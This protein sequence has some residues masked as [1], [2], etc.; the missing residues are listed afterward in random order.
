LSSL[1]ISSY[2]DYLDAQESQIS[3]F[4]VS[5]NWLQVRKGG[6]NWGVLIRSHWHGQLYNSFIK[7]NHWW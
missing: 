2:N 3:G 4:G 1:I 5:F 6:F 7:A